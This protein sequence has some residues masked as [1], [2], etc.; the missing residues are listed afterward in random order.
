MKKTIVIVMMYTAALS[1]MAQEW[2]GEYAWVDTPEEKATIEKTV[3]E[4]AQQVGR[5]I[6]FVARKRLT[7]STKPFMKLTFAVKDN[8]VTMTRDDD[9]PIA[10][11]AD[12]STLEWKRKDGAKFAVTQTL[13]GNTLTQT[14]TDSEKNTRI[15]KHIFAEDGQSLELQI[16]INSSSLKIPLNYTITYH[17]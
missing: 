10:S 5:A 16:T 13:E 2:Q 17:K 15:N 14:F 9:T 3:E 12:G 7:E 11:V 4:G 8:V 1:V 6:R